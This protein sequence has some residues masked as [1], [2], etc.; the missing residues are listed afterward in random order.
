MVKIGRN[1]FFDEPSEEDPM[2]GVANLVDAMLVIAVGLLIFLVISW[3]MQSIVFNDNVTPEQKQDA[4]N[5]M[6]QVTEIDQGKQLN[7]TPDVSN[8]SGEGYAELGKVYKDSN[9]GKL[10]M[11]EN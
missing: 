6:K 7:E 8:S 11:I 2:T 3:N 5:A 10:I 9:T 1:N 4:I